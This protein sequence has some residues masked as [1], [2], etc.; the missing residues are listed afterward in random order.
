MSTPSPFGRRTSAP[1]T[2]PR[3]EVLGEYETY[4]AAQAAVDTL[5]KAEFPIKHLSIVGTDLTTVERITGR[6]TYGR[7]AFTGAASGSWLG[8]FFGLLLF[9]FSPTPDFS[10]ILAA[11]LIGAGFGMIF[12]IV[13]YAVNRRRRDFASTHQVLARVHQVIV[14]PQ[15]AARAR[16]LLAG[17]GAWPPPVA[18]P[19]ATSAETSSAT[20]AETSSATPP[21]T[22]PANPPATPPAGTADEQ[23]A[24]APAKND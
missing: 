19:P 15:H 7:A 18:S 10:F 3:G 2:V 20:S 17:P 6:L 22:A 14:D 21:A 16:H 12:S 23:P 1:Q 4:Q 24:E 8:L 13:S 5:A 11:A 9:L